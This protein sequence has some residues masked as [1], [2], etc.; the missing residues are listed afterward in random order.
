MI[1][2]LTGSLLA[3]TMALVVIGLLMLIAT[4][5]LRK[6]GRRIACFFGRH[7]R[8]YVA[9]RRLK[10]FSGTE[11]TF[12]WF[13]RRCSRMGEKYVAVASRGSFKIEHGK[14]VPDYKA[15]ANFE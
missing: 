9:M 11:S 8:E 13:C 14:L 15:W 5:S 2:T 1:T 3:A 4:G 6:I 7:D 12:R 10:W